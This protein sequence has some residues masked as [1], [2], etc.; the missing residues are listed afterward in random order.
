MRIDEDPQH[1][2]NDFLVMTLN[3]CMFVLV[4]RLR[5]GYNVKNSSFNEPEVESII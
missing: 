4:W 1:T 3:V 5:D 2:L